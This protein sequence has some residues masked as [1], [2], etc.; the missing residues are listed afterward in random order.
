MLKVFFVVGITLIVS[1][2]FG[3]LLTRVLKLREKG[4]TA[5]LG[6]AALLFTLQIFY[7]PIQLFNLSSLYIHIISSIV[8]IG[9][10]AYAIYEFKSIFKQFWTIQTTWIIF[11][12]LAFVFVFYN[13]SI[14]ISRA[15]GQMYLNYIAQNIDNN[16]LNNFNLWTGLVGEEFVTIYLFQG[17]YHF[18]GFLVK[19][20]NVLSTVIGIGSKIDTLV[21]SL[22]GLGTI[23]SLIS[24]MFII[25]VINYFKYRNHWIPRILAIFTLFFTNFYYWKVS[26]SFYGNTWRSLFMAMF[27]YYLYRMVKEDNRK[28]IVITGI[29]FGASIAASSSSL[30]IGFSILLGFAFYLF[31][32]NSK[33]AFEDLSYIGF[34]MVLFVLAIVYKDNFKI[35]IVLLMVTLIYYCF[36]NIKIVKPII[37]IFNE[38]ISKHSN[39][40]F[41]VILPLIAIIY[42]FADMT[43]HPEYPWNLFHYFNDH[44]A[45]DMVKNY[46]FLHSDWV[47]NSLN[48][49]R[50]ISIIVL[51]FKYR[52]DKSNNY[53][54]HHFLLLAVFFLNPLTT[55]FISKMFASNVYYRAYESLFNVFTETFLFGLLLNTFW[56]KRI[57]KSLI[58]LLLLTAVVFSHYSSFVLKDKGSLYGYYIN[59]GENVLPL[60]KIKNSE[61]DV[62]RAFEQESEN[63]ETSN[64]QITVVSHVDGL[65]T[66]LP[67]VY[68]VFTARQYWSSW[69]RIDQD[70][71][72]V[73]RMWYG[74]EEKLNNIDYSKTCIY[75][76]KYKI[77]Y[78]LNEIWENSEF[79]IALNDCSEILYENYEYRL[80]KVARK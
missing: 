6:F 23:Y 78:V 13:V 4:F 69:D 31:K 59:D 65:R 79:D 34:P 22:W 43:I 10:F 51:F 54:L 32:S 46:L 19:F 64:R 17:Y 40:I 11:S 74:W 55:S 47:D 75:L 76:K 49:L 33:T 28:Y 58:I 3:I 72:Q 57:F 73:A 53:L 1:T 68:Q 18:A 61:L 30:F 44:A 62:I 35:F 20:V 7:Y 52:N 8:F 63:F 9:L 77:D 2:S 48:L 42:S 12:V 41:I 50:W 56:D 25:N 15:D 38:L 37:K 60:Y 5:P 67:N 21:V 36:H 80:R 27:M 66:F 16:Q 71:Y 29:I 39:M 14:S 24:S 26:F 70:F 45:Y